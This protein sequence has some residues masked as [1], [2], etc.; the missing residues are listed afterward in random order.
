[1]ARAYSGT[2]DQL[3]QPVTRVLSNLVTPAQLLPG[4]HIYSWRRA[5]SY[6]HH[7]IY[8]G[9]GKVIH[10]TRAEG[11]QLTGTVL[12]KIA[13]IDA[14][15]PCHVDTPCEEC[16]EKLGNKGVVCT[17]M[18]CFLQEGYLY[19]YDY[20]KSTIK[21]LLNVR[22]GTCTLALSDPCEEVLHRANYLLRNGFQCY[23]LFNSNCEDFA[24]YCKTGL[25]V[26][27]GTAVGA[28]G[29]A[30]TL[31]GAPFAMVMASPIY[32]VGPLGMAV[33][34]ISMYCLSRYVADVK[35]RPGASKIA[36]EDLVRKLALVVAPQG[37]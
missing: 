6:A 1:M 5:Y 30:T 19:R 36:V 21:F 12:D 13:S 32:I 15:V 16:G 22:G 9:N 3:L 26:V 8:I 18:I 11:Q 4:D 35:N 37:S 34:T 28:S 27:R 10:F 29:Q 25:F 14:S 24:V 33:M 17:C 2:R 7:G 31:M 20:G 23:N